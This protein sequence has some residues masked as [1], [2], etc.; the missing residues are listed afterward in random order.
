MSIQ[1]EIN[2]IV[3]FRDQSLQAVR[4]KGVTVPNDAT[5]DDLP[6]YIAQIQTGGGNAAYAIGDTYA[7]SGYVIAPGIFNSS[8]QMIFEFDVDKSL[9]DISSA[10]VT[11]L[12]GRIAGPNGP[13]DG[14]TSISSPILADTNYTIKTDIPTDH[15]VRVTV[16]KSAAIS[17]FSATVPLMFIGYITLKFA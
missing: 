13:V 16:T 8:T 3:S 11:R 12:T 1:S 7:P 14:K 2:R 5:I 15:S 17:G 10:T 4:D 9:G 6:G